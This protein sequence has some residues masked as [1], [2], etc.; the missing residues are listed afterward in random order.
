MNIFLTFDYELFFGSITGTVEKCMIEPTNKLLQISKKYSVPMTFFVDVGYLIRLE[1]E[2]A[3]HSK[4]K[5]D[6]AKVKNQITEMLECG[7]DVQLHIH[8]HWERSYYNGEKWI[9]EVD[10]CY[11]L[12]DFDDD[13]LYHIVTFYKDYLEEIS[14]KKVHT[15]RAGGWCIQP[16]DRLK[17]IFKE[18]GIKFDTSVFTGGHFE[19]PHY[20]FDFRKAPKKSMYRFENDVCEEVENGSFVEYPIASLNY[21][22]LFYWRL[23]ILGRLF[24]KRHKMVGDG[25]FLSQPGRKKSVLTNFTW[26]HV[27]TDGYYVTKLNES[28]INCQNNQMQEMVTIGHP[29]S[30]T[31]FSFEILDK[32]IVTNY[33]RHTFCS[34]EKLV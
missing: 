7:C 19:S 17:D 16:F 3:K 27:S 11:K 1:T 12:A 6:L 15:F 13:E 33:I 22:P 30:C 5:S 20:N 32:F 14:R 10:G 2:S 24:P 28:L 29:K 34:F 4:L 21:S 26:N 9:I 18:I 31:L 25:N 23:Y 8:P